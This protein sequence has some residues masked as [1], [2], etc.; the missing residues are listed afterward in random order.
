MEF[1]MASAVIARRAG[2]A[3]YTDGFVRRP[4]VQDLMRRV[5]IETN[6][7]YDPE[8]SGAS[9]WDQVRIDLTAGGS[10]GS[11]KVRRAKGHADRPLSEAELF[12]KFRTCLHASGAQIAPDVLF[13]RLKHLESQSAWELT[14]VG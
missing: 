8:V 5:G 10:I 11:E 3:E 14:S 9:V 7:H 6:Q 1:A 12:E 13:D 4:E 2:L